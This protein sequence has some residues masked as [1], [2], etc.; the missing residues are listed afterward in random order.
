M[1]KRVVAINN[2]ITLKGDVPAV[3]YLVTGIG[4]HK[5]SKVADYIDENGHGR[6]AYYTQIARVFK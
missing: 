1:S 3:K 2:N 5:G 4:E 6:F